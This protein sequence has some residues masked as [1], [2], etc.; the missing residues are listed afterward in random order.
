MKT[1][2]TICLLLLVTTAQGQG[3]FVLWDE[4]VNGPLAADYTS[5]TSLS[6]VQLGINSIVAITENE[7]TG[8][9]HAVHADY[10]TFVVPDGLSVSSLQLQVDKPH[11]WMWIGDSDFANQLAFSDNPSTG[12]LLSQWGLS[13]I[14]G[15]TYGM[16][17]ANLDAQSSTS[18]AKYRLDFSVTAVPEPSTVALLLLGGLGLIVRVRHF[19]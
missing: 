10:F 6:P 1:Y 17:V 3:T 8:N 16:Y 4:S 11:I 5:A 19:R 2:L 7:P 9:S 15:G 18:I 14:G 13:S 12:E